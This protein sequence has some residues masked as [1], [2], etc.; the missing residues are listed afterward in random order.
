[1]VV[2]VVVCARRGAEAGLVQCRWQ[3]DKV[4]HGARVRF[5]PLGA[6]FWV[7]CF[8]SPAECEQEVPPSTLLFPR[9]SFAGHE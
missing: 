1:M 9:T 3:G 8:Y 6:L 5:V 4:M 7:R 2:V